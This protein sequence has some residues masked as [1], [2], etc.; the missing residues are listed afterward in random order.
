MGV[1]T[2]ASKIEKNIIRP[3]LSDIDG[4]SLTV[5]DDWLSPEEIQEEL[6]DISSFYREKLEKLIG[7]K[8]N[9]SEKEEALIKL[10]KECLEE[11]DELVWVVGQEKTT[12][13][14][15]QEYLWY[16][17]G[18]LNK[19]LMKINSRHKSNSA[20]WIPL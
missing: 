10:A 6:T 14:V 8:D 17:L 15:M 20:T 13:D 3:M 19:K 5:I 12:P 7:R 2:H 11:L 9:F 4:L 1:K 18:G 16:M